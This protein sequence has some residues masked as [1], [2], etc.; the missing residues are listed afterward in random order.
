MYEA[1]TSNDNGKGE[2]RVQGMRGEV[3]RTRYKILALFNL[4]ALYQIRLTT[5]DHL[6]VASQLENRVL[7]ALLLMRQVAK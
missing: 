7:M 5:V 6:E 4:T 2:N 3:S 1:T